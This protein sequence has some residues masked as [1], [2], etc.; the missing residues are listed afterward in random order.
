MLKFPDVVGSVA[1][2]TDSWPIM[3]VVPPPLT[4]AL[5]GSFSSGPVRVLSAAR[6]VVAYTSS[7]YLCSSVNDGKLSSGLTF[8]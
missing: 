3:K 1:P 6:N 5:D 7:K 8:A 2:Q 4:T